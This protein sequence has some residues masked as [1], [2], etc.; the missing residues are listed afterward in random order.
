MPAPNRQ[1]RAALRRQGPGPRPV[2]QA[3][4]SGLD[5]K[6]A[7]RPAVVRWPAAAPRP[8]PALAEARMPAGKQKTRG[9]KTPVDEDIAATGASPDPKP[10]R[11]TSRSVGR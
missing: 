6:A 4:V 9:C 7:A 8:I 1:G 10:I 2:A 11:V 3:T 5:R